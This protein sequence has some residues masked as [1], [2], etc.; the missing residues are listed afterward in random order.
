M[1]CIETTTMNKDVKSRSTATSVWDMCRKK[2]FAQVAFVAAPSFSTARPRRGRSRAKAPTISVPIA[3][4]SQ[5]LP[6]RNAQVDI[7][8]TKQDSADLELP[9]CHHH[10]LHDPR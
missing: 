7:K 2:Q 9:N 10:S 1:K 8:W 6:F 5:A 3:I 4:T